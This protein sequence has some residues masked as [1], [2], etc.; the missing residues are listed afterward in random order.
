MESTTDEK[1][2]WAPRISALLGRWG[3]ETHGIA[4]IPVEQRVDP[5]TWQHFLLWFS[6]NVNLPTMV[7]G[8]GGP[9]V[10]NMS[11][12]DTAVVLLVSDAV[13]SII[14]AYFALF[15]PRL[16]TR[17]MVQ[18]RYSWGVRAVII[19]SLFNVLS[20]AG[21]L[22]LNAIVAG[23]LLST[24]SSR[25]NPTAGIIII[26]LVSLVASFCGYRSLH[27]FQGVSWLPTLLGI[28]VMLA[29]GAPHLRAITIPASTPPTV[30]AVLSFSAAVMA[31]VF[32]WCTAMADYGVY[33]K[34]DTSSAL[35][36]TYVYA[37]MFSSSFMMHLL[38]AVFACAATSGTAPQW[39]AAYNNGNNFG[40]LASAV[41]APSR[42]F[43]KLMMALMSLAISAPTALTMYSFGM[44]LMNVSTWFARV[45]RYV[46]A[47][48]ATAICVPLAI[49]GQT[50]FYDVLVAII[51]IIGYWSA[52]F[53]A[54]I[55]T[56]HIVFRD[57][58]FSSYD[59]S[60]WDN[61]QSLPP[62]IAAVLSFTLSFALIV[63]CMAQSFF[64][65]PIAAAFGGGDVGLIVGFFSTSFLYAG[66][67]AVER[68]VFRR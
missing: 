44:S 67:R 57:A 54:I 8:A 12:R 59:V 60:A 65:G 48:V 55:F 18:A 42:G 22:V 28:I 13:A 58:T 47:V 21:Y 20:M 45:P 1:Q 19:P 9:V 4:P 64:V 52:S 17:Q 41:L 38:G 31:S 32:S 30:A 37:A 51:D 24:I 15:G 46:F 10:F 66:L 7:I 39:W 6:A 50:R 27:W 43:G 3:V 68:R 5:R 29:I 53:A 49:A 14:P 35:I 25:L 40:G 63:P 11:F 36:F 62:G 33:H 16:G 56:E 2:S 26:S 34:A 61:A 23:Q